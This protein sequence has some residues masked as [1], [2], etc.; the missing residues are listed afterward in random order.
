[1]QINIGTVSETKKRENAQAASIYLKEENVALNNF[2]HTG[3]EVAAVR[4]EKTKP[5][6]KKKT[7][8]AAKHEKFTYETGGGPKQ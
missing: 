2:N 3:L 8:V 6:E 7:F 4:G 5:K 1:M